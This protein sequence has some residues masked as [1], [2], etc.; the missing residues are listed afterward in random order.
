VLTFTLVD[1]EGLTAIVCVDNAL[2][3]KVG[4]KFVL[5]RVQI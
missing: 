5:G 2:L 4:T 1:E 3:E